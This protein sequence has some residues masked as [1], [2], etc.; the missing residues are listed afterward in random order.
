MLSLD[1]GLYIYIDDGFIYSGNVT[2]SCSH[3]SSSWHIPTWWKYDWWEYAGRPPLSSLLYPHHSWIWP[4][5]PYCVHILCPLLWPFTYMN[6]KQWIEISKLREVNHQDYHHWC[7]YWIIVTIYN[8]IWHLQGWNEVF[9]LGEVDSWEEVVEEVVAEPWHHC[10]YHHHHQHHP[11]LCLLQCFDHRFWMFF[12]LD[13]LNVL[14]I[15]LECF[16]KRC[17][18]QWDAQC[19]PG[20][21]SP[22]I[23]TWWKIIRE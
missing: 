16:A 19:S 20:L 1:W 13:V 8:A 4:Y 6:L 17:Q 18:L 9:K 22:A 15:I 21:L 5:Y 12:V 14:I 11:L 10:H 7:H 2:L 23:S 3:P